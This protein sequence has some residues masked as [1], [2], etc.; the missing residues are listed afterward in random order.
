MSENY[1]Y[2]SNT[3]EGNI[4]TSETPSSRRSSISQDSSLSRNEYH[5]FKNTQSITDILTK[6]EQSTPII[7][8]N[9]LPSPTNREFLE[10]YNSSL[11]DLVFTWPE[12]PKG[13]KSAY[14]LQQNIRY[15]RL[16]RDDSRSHPH[17]K[18]MSGKSVSFAN[19]DNPA[20]ID[21]LKPRADYLSQLKATPCKDHED[22]LSI[23]SKKQSNIE[24]RELFNEASSSFSK[25]KYLSYRKQLDRSLNIKKSSPQSIYYN[26]IEK[27]RNSSLSP[28]NEVQNI[29]ESPTQS[30]NDAQYQISK[31]PLPKISPEKSYSP[32]NEINE[33]FQES[34]PKSVSSETKSK[35]SNSSRTNSR[36][37]SLPSN[38]SNQS[39]YTKKSIKEESSPVNYHSNEFSSQK[40]NPISVDEDNLIVKKTKRST[41]TLSRPSTSSSV[42]S[43]KNRNFFTNPL[44][45]TS[46]D[47]TRA[48]LK[49]RRSLPLHERYSKPM[50]TSHEYGWNL[51]TKKSTNQE[52]ENVVFGKN[53][54]EKTSYFYITT[55]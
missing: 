19:W 12:E 6:E 39:N 46:E 52:T 14:L 17:F 54:P 24:S 31:S 15:H 51:E 43:N 47:S 20:F 44:S 25:N 45:F 23:N 11:K 53:V 1:S 3:N 7:R 34:I 41:S 49:L 9:I 10:N 18:T 2:N 48:K 28:S 33:Y 4:L 30:I 36:R 26:L 29:N 21:P 35:I 50:T 32:S 37:Y 55:F 8:R 27:T 5:N 13:P 38:L 40:I 22:S 16:D 42:Y